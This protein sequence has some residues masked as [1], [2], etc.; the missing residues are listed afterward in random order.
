MAL[1]VFT[2]APIDVPS[3]GTRVQV[4]STYSPV[5]TITF[6]AAE[7]N[8]GKVYI[9]DSNVASGRGISLDP[10]EFL[11]VSADLSGRSGGEELDLSDW[12]VDAETSGNDVKILY[13]KRKN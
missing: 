3:A 13:M 6:Q 10:G 12:W 4:I 9:G 7:G 2:L 1:K 5:S 11:S 8:T